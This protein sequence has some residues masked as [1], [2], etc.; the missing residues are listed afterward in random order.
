M[1]C[2]KYT[3]KDTGRII[4]LPL[5]FVLAFYVKLFFLL[6]SLPYASNYGR[7]NLNCFSD[8][9]SLEGSIKTF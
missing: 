3:P 8:E 2:P 1:F 5:A 7:C 9:M 4:L 6:F